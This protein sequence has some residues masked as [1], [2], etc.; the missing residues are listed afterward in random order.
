MPT[1]G[2]MIMTKVI[3]I[4]TTLVPGQRLPASAMSL[5]RLAGLER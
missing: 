5:A 1:E 2:G 4:A 3:F